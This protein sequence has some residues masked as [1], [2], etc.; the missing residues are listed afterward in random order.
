[1]SALLSCR[2]MSNQIPWGIYRWGCSGFGS[3][4]LP[5]SLPLE[6]LTSKGNILEAHGEAGDE[7]SVATPDNMHKQLM[8][9]YVWWHYDYMPLV[10]TVLSASVKTEEQLLSTPKRQPGSLR[11]RSDS[12]SHL[13]QWIKEYS[14]SNWEGEAKLMP[15]VMAES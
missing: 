9:L 3:V 6:K 14:S 11:Q 10:K 1:M 7:E 15:K 12:R 4:W 2:V 13:P 8:A 5:F